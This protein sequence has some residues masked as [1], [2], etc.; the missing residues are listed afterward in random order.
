M[1]KMVKELEDLVG[2]VTKREV[3]K[4]IE[5]REGE[6]QLNLVFSQMGLVYE[7]HKARLKRKKRMPMGVPTQS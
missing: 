3:E 1:A 2:P 4:G 6:V 7:A 5:L